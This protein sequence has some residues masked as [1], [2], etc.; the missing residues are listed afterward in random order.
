MLLQ[1]TEQV[2]PS[3]VPYIVTLIVAI[4]SALSAWIIARRKNESEAE[5]NVSE[6]TLN[7]SE[8]I[9]NYIKT[10]SDLQSQMDTWL[11][12]IKDLRV[13]VNTV[14]ELNSELEKTLH[15]LQE[16]EYKALIE[17]HLKYK[18][19]RDRLLHAVE[20]LIKLVRPVVDTL[21]VN[22]EFVK[23]RQE[24]IVILE[25]LYRLR[26]RLQKDP[27]LSED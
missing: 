10:V 20:K 18:R 19:E 27:D 13:E 17:V 6:A 2:N 12:K 25:T 23:L 9:Q 3:W 14:E 24:S 15:G 8:I 4:I 11:T 26:D 22:P 21:A 7:E 5:K 16:K 1:N